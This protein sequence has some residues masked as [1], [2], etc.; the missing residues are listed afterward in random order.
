MRTYCLIIRHLYNHM[1]S[2]SMLWLCEAVKSGSKTP[3]YGKAIS[4][5]FRLRTPTTMD[6][7][8]LFTAAN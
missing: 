8:A 3:Q 7:T 2:F 4:V 6:H 1:A 5:C